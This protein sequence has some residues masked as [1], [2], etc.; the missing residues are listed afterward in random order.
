M[1]QNTNRNKDTIERNLQAIDNRIEQAFQANPLNTILLAWLK[2]YLMCCDTAYTSTFGASL[3]SILT[4]NVVGVWGNFNANNSTGEY[5]DLSLSS[6]FILMLLTGPGT[7]RVRGMVTETR[8]YTETM[9]IYVATSHYMP[10]TWKNIRIS[11][12]GKDKTTYNVLN[13]MTYP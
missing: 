10:N 3:Q 1:R 8:F 4:T 7:L 12:V 6:M 5:N 13:E 11:G 2:G 9:G